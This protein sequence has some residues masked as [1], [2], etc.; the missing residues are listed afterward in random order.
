MKGLLF[1][2]GGAAILLLAFV[3]FGALC[4]WM[5]LVLGTA[6]VRAGASFMETAWIPEELRRNADDLV[7]VMPLAAAVLAAM[8]GGLPILFTRFSTSIVQFLEECLTLPAGKHSWW[9]EPGQ[10]GLVSSFLAPCPHLIT[11]AFL[12][13]SYGAPADPLRPPV[14]Y[15]FSPDSSMLSVLPLN[16]LLYFENAAVGSA[17]E[18]TERGTTLQDARRVPLKEFVQKLRRC[19]TSDR[20]VT[21]RPY[22]FASDDPFLTPGV[23]SEESDVLNVAAANRRAR[24]VYDALNELISELIEP[25]EPGGMTVEAP[26]E[27]D[28]FEEMTSERDSMIRVPDGSDRD[29]FADRVAVLRLMSFGACEADRRNPPWGDFLLAFS[30]FCVIVEEFS[31]FGIYQ[32]MNRRVKETERLKSDATRNYAG[33]IELTENAQN[34]HK[35]LTRLHEQAN[36]LYRNMSRQSRE[37]NESRQAV[38]LQAC[39]VVGIIV[40]ALT[41]MCR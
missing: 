29:P 36:T 26:T 37:W 40:L 22:G 8:H 18:L 14:T 30:A 17:G 24:A 3:A 5:G 32:V 33:L 41:S 21:I 34:K 10:A 12:F 28:T 35:E 4:L 16:P 13:G 11:A 20:P 19:A 23:D 1:R 2:W 6:F 25:E 9:G 15:V 7:S 27:W 39:G 31:L 38:L